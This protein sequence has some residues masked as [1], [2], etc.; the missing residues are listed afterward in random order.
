MERECAQSEKDFLYKNK[1]QMLKSLNEIQYRKVEKTIF[2]EWLVILGVSALSLLSLFL[3]KFLCIMSEIYLSNEDMNI[4][5]LLMFVFEWIILKLIQKKIIIDKF[6]KECVKREHIFING[7][8]IVKKHKTKYTYSILYIEDD[9]I[10]SNG[11][12]PVRCFNVLKSDYKKLKVG[13]RLILIK[14]KIDD[15]EYLLQ[16]I[17][18]DNELIAMIPSDAKNDFSEFDSTNSMLYPHI[19]LLNVKSEKRFFSESEK[20][21]LRKL[22]FEQQRNDGKV[23]MITVFDFMRTYWNLLGLMIGFCEKMSFINFLIYF[24]L[25]NVFLLLISWIS[26]GIYIF[27]H[28]KISN[29]RLRDKKELMNFEYAREVLIQSEIFRNKLEVFAYKLSDDGEVLGVSNVR[30]EYRDGDIVYECI[31]NSGKLSRT[32]YVPIGIFN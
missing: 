28:K 19:N 16:I 8:T 31:E 29:K 21:E 9:K 18:A 12:K 15:K 6:I 5:M 30:S 22:V 24:N 23:E 7:A 14:E 3:F 13:D 26:L 17:R 20:E 10:D 1:K 2:K 32:Y 27:L 25:F 11:E 4:V